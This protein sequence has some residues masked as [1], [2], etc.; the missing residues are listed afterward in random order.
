MPY[1]KQSF[2]R[3]RWWTDI[4]IS[5]RTQRRKQILLLFGQNLFYTF[6]TR[7]KSEDLPRFCVFSEDLHS[8]VSGAKINIYPGMHISWSNILNYLIIFKPSITGSI[9]TEVG[10]TLSVYTQCR[11][12]LSFFFYFNFLLENRRYTH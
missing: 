10:F 9:V 11:F 8:F 4:K 12:V 2:I 7:D 6:C 1:R 3:S 5:I